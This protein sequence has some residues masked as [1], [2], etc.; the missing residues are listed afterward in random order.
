MNQQYEQFDHIDFSHPKVQKIIN[1]A[2]EVFTKNDLSKASTNQIVKLAGISRGLLYHYFK[3]KQELYDY[4]IFF[5]MKV[6]VVEMNDKMDWE[7]SDFI[8]RMICVTK[9]RFEI[10]KTYPYMSSFFQKYINQLDKNEM[11]ATYNKIHPG[12]QDKFYSYNLDFSQLKD[13]VDKEKVIHVAKWTVKGKL[14]DW[15]EKEQA[16]KDT[17]DVDR[18]IAE[19][20]DYLEFL[21]TVFYKRGGSDEA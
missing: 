8:N 2:Y 20:I 6:G 18:L 17:D 16:G 12:L 5:A 15:K 10:M 7:D 13:G 14:A 19:C 21:R 9:I 11:R 4:L 3:D 1:C